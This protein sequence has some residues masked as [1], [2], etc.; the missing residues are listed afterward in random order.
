MHTPR[1]PKPSD[2]IAARNRANA[3][4]STGPRSAAGKAA[5]SRNAV[6]HGLLSTH[7]LAVGD[8]DQAAMDAHSIAYCAALGAAHREAH[9]S[10]STNGAQYPRT[11]PCAP[12]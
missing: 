7:P 10:H 9:G 2:A 5:S 12:Y 8:E 11:S 4:L 3:Q 1:D 6:T